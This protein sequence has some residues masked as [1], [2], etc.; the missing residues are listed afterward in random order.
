MLDRGVYLP[1]S[2]YEAWFPSL[3]HTRRARRAH[4]RGRPRGA[5]GAVSNLAQLI[6]AAGPDLA[7]HANPQPGPD[8]FVRATSRAPTCSRPSTRRYLLHYGEP[9]AFV[10]MDADLRLLAGDALYAQGLAR[11][12]EPGDLEAVAELADLISLCAWARGRRAPRAGRRALGRERPAAAGGTGAARGPRW[13]ATWRRTPVAD[14]TPAR[15]TP[16]SALG[17][18]ELPPPRPHGRTQEEPQTEEVP[19]HRRPRH[20]RRVRGRDRHAPARCSTGGAQAVGGIAVGGVRAARARLRA[21]PDVRGPAARR[22]SRTSAPRTTS[23]PRPTSRRSSRSSPTSGE[24]GK[25]TIYVRKTDP[26]RDD[27]EERRTSPYVAISTRCVHLGCPVRYVQASRALHLPVPRRRLRL[28]GRGRPAARRCARSTASTRRSRHG[29]VMVGARFSLN[30][31]L[32]RFAPRDPSNHLDGLW[33]YLY[34]SRPTHMKLPK[35]PL[36][37]SLQRRPARPART[38]RGR[39]A[40]ASTATKPTAKEHAAEGRRSRRRLARRAH[41]R[42]PV[43]ARLPLPQGPEGH[44]LVLHA[45]LGLDVRLPLAGGHGRLPGDVLRPDP[46]RPTSRPRASPTRSSSA[47]SSAACTAG[48]RR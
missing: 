36:P 5:G 47:S 35:P 31:K 7:A 15:A 10:G 9:R 34:P 22:A 12:A 44:E 32:E 2:Q 41:R 30:S 6:A 19:L 37:R 42:E 39:T 1:P 23:T 16:V 48:A 13:R 25:T 3:A 29:R 24:A 46:T 14:W 17:T 21:R 33:Q 45:R 18:V 43:P 40:T 4:A 38:A 27:E 28:P 26:E 11:L 8:R 20:R